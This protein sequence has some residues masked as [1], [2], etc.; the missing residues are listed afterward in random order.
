MPFL[1]PHS[2]FPH[3]FAPKTPI[4]P[5]SHLLLPRYL[6]KA[7]LDGWIKQM[8]AAKVELVVGIVAPGGVQIPITTSVL[9]RV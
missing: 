8:R 9:S 4:L 7:T 5:P 3:H 6:S 1:L 2:Y